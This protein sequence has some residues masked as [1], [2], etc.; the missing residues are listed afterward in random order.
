MPEGFTPPKSAD[1]MARA[2]RQTSAS[3]PNVMD[4]IPR[5][6]WR[7]IEE[8]LFT[9]DVSRNLQRATDRMPKRGGKLRIPAGVYYATDWRADGSDGTKRDILYEGDGRASWIR[10]PDDANLTTAQAKRSNVMHTKAGRGF[11]FRDFGLEGNRSRGGKQ[12][13]YGAIWKTGT[14]YTVA[15]H[16]TTTFSTKADGTAYTTGD[17]SVLA[18]QNGGRMFR[19][20][21]NHTSHASD[22]DNDLASGNVTEVTNQPW[23]ERTGTGHLD[24]WNDDD[25][26]QHRHALYLH[27]ED[28]AITDCLIE[29]VETCDAVYGG[30]VIGSGP[31]F[32]DGKGAGAVNCR[33][34]NCYSHDNGGSNF[35]GGHN[36]FPRDV[37]ATSR[38]GYSS[39]FRYDE[40]SDDPTLI[41]ALI[42]DGQNLKNGGILNYKSDRANI[43]LPRIRDASLAIW[44][45]DSLD[46]RLLYDDPGSGSNT[47]SNSTEAP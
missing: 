38:G 42:L 7:A 34:V 33:R 23:D 12:P 8:G 10:K 25:D 37:L 45:Q 24:H 41:A 40:G 5:E 31:I 11:V 14:A 20:A 29:N 43:L 4:D 22:I 30:N 3:P 39:G 27:G 19:I 13:P 26:Y 36:L 46:Y 15:S 9:G 2:M 44:I 18:V 21:R 16:G 17:R 47:I 1:E 28:E 6:Y 32:A 35:G